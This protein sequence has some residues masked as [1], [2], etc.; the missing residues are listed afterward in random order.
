MYDLLRINFVPGRLGRSD[1]LSLLFI[2]IFITV[3]GLCYGKAEPQKKEAVQSDSLPFKPSAWVAVGGCWDFS[4]RI[5]SAQATVSCCRAYLADRV[6]RDF[7]FRVRLNKL[8]EDGAIGVIFRFDE[9]AHT[10]YRF[11]IYPH[12]G[13]ILALVRGP[14]REGELWH[15]TAIVMNR[16]C[17][18]WNRIRITCTG[19]RM[20]IYIN[21]EL[22]NIVE[23]ST[24]A[25]G[26]IGLFIGG[27][28]RQRAEFEILTLEEHSR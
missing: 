28:P 19:K 7:T 11:E 21:G 24:Y 25:S 10:G 16:G 9:T 18:T 26:R 13:H 6:Y 27:D 22:A 12:G 2:S 4:H 8:A 14:D 1:T 5:I 17:N 23:D 3:G 15:S 20:E